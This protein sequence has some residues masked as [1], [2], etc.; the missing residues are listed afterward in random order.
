MIVGVDSYLTSRRHQPL[1]WARS[2]AHEKEL[3]RVH[4][5]EAA[6]AIF[7]A[8]SG[9]PVMSPAWASHGRKLISTT[10]R[11]FLFEREGMTS[12]YKEAIADQGA[13]IPISFSRSETLSAKRIGSSRR[14]LA[15]LRTQREHS[16]VQPI[17]ALGGEPGEYRGGRCSRHAGLGVAAI[18]REYAPSGPI[19]V[20]ASGD[21][22]ACGALPWWRQDDGFCKRARNLGEAQGC[23]VIAAFPDICFTRPK[24]LQRHRA[25]PSPIPIS[26]STPI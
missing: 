7:C 24:I 18:Q 25:C 5:G 12:A 19:L 17:W 2:D 26:G 8:R 14:A 21:D 1:S 16:K 20:E 13:S 6:A 23:K 4:P 9:G 15:M 11:K 10:R 3:E 22:G